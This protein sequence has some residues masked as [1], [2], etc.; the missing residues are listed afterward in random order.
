MFALRREKLSSLLAECMRV[1]FCFKSTEQHFVF[2]F[3]LDGVCVCA[4]GAPQRVERLCNISKFYLHN[5]PCAS[6]A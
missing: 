5:W 3:V 1:K 2:L 4:I 6:V